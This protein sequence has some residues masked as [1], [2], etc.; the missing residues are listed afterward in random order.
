VYMR[1]QNFQGTS[2]RVLLDISKVL[3]SKRNVRGL[4]RVCVCVC[5]FD[6]RVCVYGHLLLLLL[7]LLLW[8]MN[9]LCTKAQCSSPRTQSNGGSSGGTVREQ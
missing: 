8:E 2:S 9:G 1:C 7:L 6:A 3:T 5:V 4:M